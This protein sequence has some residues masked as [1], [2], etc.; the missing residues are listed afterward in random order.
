MRH[1]NLLRY[2]CDWKDCERVFLT[3]SQLKVHKLAHSGDKPHA[4]QLCDKRY[5]TL[6]KLKVHQNKQHPNPTPSA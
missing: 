6:N 5:P 3:G 4:C 1:K 2:R